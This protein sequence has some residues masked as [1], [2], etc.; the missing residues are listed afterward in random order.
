MRKAVT[1]MRSRPRAALF[2]ILLILQMAGSPGA[3]WGQSPFDWKPFGVDKDLLP[4]LSAELRQRDL[5]LERAGVGRLE[6][7]GIGLEKPP[8]V[9]ELSAPEARFGHLRLFL[10][11]FPFSGVERDIE[12]P[13][14]DRMGAFDRLKT[15]PG[16]L[17]DNPGRAFESMGE[18]FQPQLNLGIEF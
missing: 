4:D 6:G 18:I 12:G 11:R 2:V 3:V 8:A 16:N 17:R 10:S 7:R 9:E 14:R 13:M 5:F 1:S 15:V